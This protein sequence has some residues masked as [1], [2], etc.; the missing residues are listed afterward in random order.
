MIGG[1][2][3]RFHYICFGDD[4]PKKIEREYNRLCRQEQYQEEK[5]LAHGVLHLDFD[6]LL[7]GTVDQTSLPKY[8]KELMIRQQRAARLEILPKALKW[9][10]E[11]FPDDFAIISDY[12]LSEE[13]KITLVYLAEKYGLTHQAMSKR[14]AR[15]R[16]KLKE[17]IILHENQE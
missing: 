15:A 14:M 8:Q 16:E 11:E 13:K 7:Q 5:E 3:G 1:C 12:Y 2:M 17:F 9:L 6:A 4:V 10:K